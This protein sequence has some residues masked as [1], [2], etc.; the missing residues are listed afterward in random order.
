MLPMIVGP[1][2]LPLGYASTWKKLNETLKV[3]I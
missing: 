2:K 3:G 1:T